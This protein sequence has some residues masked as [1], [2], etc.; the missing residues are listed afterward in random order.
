VASWTIIDAEDDRE[1]GTVRYEGYLDYLGSDFDVEEI[2][3]GL[4]S[5][6]DSFPGDLDRAS[7]G[8]YV[9]V[10]DDEYE[11]EAEEVDPG[12]DAALDADEADL[13][14]SDGP[15]APAWEAVFT[16]GDRPLGRLLGDGARAELDV[17]DPALHGALLVDVLPAIEALGLEPHRAEYREALRAAVEGLPGRSIRVE[18]RETRSL[19]GNQ[20]GDLPNAVVRYGSSS[21]DWG[22]PAA[23]WSPVPLEPARKYIKAN[24]DAAIEVNFP[25]VFEEDR[26]AKIRDLLQ[27]DLAGFISHR[28]AAEQYA[29]EMGFEQ[30]DYAQEQEAIST[31]KPRASTV[32]G[33]A[34]E[35]AG[36]G[37]GAPG[38]GGLPGMKG[39]AGQ[40]K[41]QGVDG[42][43]RNL[44]RAKVAGGAP[45]DGDRGF[46]MKQD[47]L[48]EE[49]DDLEFDPSAE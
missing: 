38:G 9:A 39:I 32:Q 45:E 21:P 23:P 22:G 37:T 41:P 34:Q 13:A 11:A 29:K 30:F 26:S 48:T 4:S 17:Q 35:M 43:G 16:E 2:V 42:P 18:V 1:V 6:E 8:R 47:A 10:Q 24:P 12:V 27:G 7:G 31:E 25:T 28:R 3:Q 49:D 33:L 15:L 14:E 5:D 19:G 20:G 46:K 44:V 40:S 36:P